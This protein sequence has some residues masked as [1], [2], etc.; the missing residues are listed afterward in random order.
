M[1]FNFHNLNTLVLILDTLVP[2]AF[3]SIQTPRSHLTRTSQIKEPL[4]RG[5]LLQ[6]HEPLQ[7][8][9]RY[10]YESKPK[11][12]PETQPV[13]EPQPSP[14]PAPTPAQFQRRKALEDE[15]TVLSRSILTKR[16]F[17]SLGSPGECGGLKDLFGAL[18]G[19]VEGGG[20]D[21]EATLLDDWADHLG[22]EIRLIKTR[23]LDDDN[24]VQRIEARLREVEEELD[25]LP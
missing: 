6:D 2:G 23:F 12:G 16:R 20:K 8:E 9:P 15:Y 17:F 25:A 18:A 10:E 5:G 3:I 1:S 13:Q 24:E 4:Q 7:S 11:S 22:E 19:N 21:A 14:P